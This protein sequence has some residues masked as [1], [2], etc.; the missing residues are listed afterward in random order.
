MVTGTIT[1]IY[2]RVLDAVVAGPA[3]VIIGEVVAARQAVSADLMN[4][5]TISQ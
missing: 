4:E 3:L 2:Q 5:S 1:T